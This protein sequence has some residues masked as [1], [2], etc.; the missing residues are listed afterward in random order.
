MLSHTFLPPYIVKWQR[1]K[2]ISRQA[3]MKAVHDQ[4]HGATEDAMETAHKKG[5]KGNRERTLGTGQLN[6]R[7][8]KAPAMSSTVQQVRH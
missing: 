2:D 8:R 5:K 6:R 3:Q 1:N 4:Q 7:T